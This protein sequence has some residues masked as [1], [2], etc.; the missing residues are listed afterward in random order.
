MLT[1]QLTSS[2]NSTGST[3]VYFAG[4]LPTGYTLFWVRRLPNEIANLVTPLIA[5]APAGDWW[6]LP[7]YVEAGTKY[8]VPETV[9]QKHSKLVE[10]EA[11]WKHRREA[12]AFDTV[13][14]LAGSM[15]SPGVETSDEELKATLREMR[16]AWEAEID[17]YLDGE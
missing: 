14:S 10:I 6:A 17:G 2:S 3:G 4:V 12:G 7:G 9:E 5:E 1:P 8:R 15:A 11:E 13:T 16:T